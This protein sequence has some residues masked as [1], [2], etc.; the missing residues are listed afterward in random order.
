M[1]KFLRMVNWYLVSQFGVNIRRFLFTL[2]GMPKIVRDYL[3]FRKEYGADFGVHLCI[4]DHLAEN[5]DISNEYF[6][7][8]LYVAQ[9]ISSRLPRRHLDVGSHVAGFVAHVA[10][11]REVDVVDIRPQSK[12]IKNI[13]FMQYDFSSRSIRNLQY[14][15][16]S[17]LHALEHFGLGRYGDTIDKEA[18]RNGLINLANAVSLGGRLYL[19]LP[20]GIEKIYFNS[21]RISDPVKILEFT[22]ELGLVVRSFACVSEGVLRPCYDIIQELNALRSREY[23]LGIYEF[24]KTA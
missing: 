6:L 5:G 21:H 10:S 12:D 19:S 24:E 17:C 13:T 9:K 23:V 1:I 20:I 4:G 18:F 22:Q 2:R 16:V 7:Q 11:F 3:V 8:D 15:S 14:D